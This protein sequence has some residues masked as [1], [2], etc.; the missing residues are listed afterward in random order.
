MRV[1]PQSLW[2]VVPSRRALSFA[3]LGKSG[4]HRRNGLEVLQIEHQRPG[5]VIAKLVE[6]LER[7][8]WDEDVETTQKPQVASDRHYLHIQRVA[9]PSRSRRRD[10]EQVPNLDLQ[11]L[12]LL[13]E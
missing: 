5:S 6:R 12:C 9:S 13:V 2:T 10:G 11:L 3:G 7:P 8:D 4:M 1:E